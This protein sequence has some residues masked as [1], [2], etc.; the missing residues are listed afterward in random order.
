M[1]RR[2]ILRMGA[3]TGA[4]ALGTAAAGCGGLTEALAPPSLPISDSDMKQFLARL[5]RS[6]NAISTT[7]ALSSLLPKKAIDRLDTDD[8]EFK[9]GDQLF[10]KT[11]RSMLLAGS[12][13]DL[14]DEGRVHPGMQ[15]RMWRA[16]PEMDDAM[17]GMTRM[18][19][20]LSPTERVDIGRALRKDPDLGMRIVGALDN[21]AAAAGVTMARRMHLRSIGA[22]TSFRLKQSAPLFIEEYTGKVRKIVDRHGGDEDVKRRM[23]AQMGQAAYLGYQERLNDLASRWSM[24]R[25]DSEDEES[26]NDNVNGPYAPGAGP[27][28]EP[29]GGTAMTVGGILLGVGLVTAVIGASIMAAGEFGGVFV[30]TAGAVIGVGGLITL[31]VGIVLRATS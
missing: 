10:R 18:F 9:K 20:S 11:L 29:R 2:D 4:G 5:D 23:A 27:K 8:P 6:M 24:G 12:F 1:E 14:P 25:A 16:M 21:E 30:I 28:K 3:L 17:L 26:T 31:I 15:D 22:D 13:K 19:E 7:N